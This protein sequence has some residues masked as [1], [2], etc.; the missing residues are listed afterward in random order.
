[1]RHVAMGLCSVLVL[2]SAGLADP[3]AVVGDQPRQTQQTQWWVRVDVKG[4]SV[5]IDPQNGLEG[6]GFEGA[7]RVLPTP[8]VAGVHS[9]DGSRVAFLGTPKGE[10]TIDL[11]VSDL[12]RSAGTAT[13]TNV[14]RITRG[15]EH[16][17]EPRWMHDNRTLLYVATS[18]GLQQVYRVDV[19]PWRRTQP[20]DEPRSER[21]SDGKTRSYHAR[22]SSDGK[23]AFL[24]MRGRD[25]KASLDDLVV[26]DGE[27]TKVVSSGEMILGLEFSPDGSKIAYSTAGKLRIHDL[28]TKQTHAW[29]FKD[30]SADH[31][32]T[33]HG[34]YDIAWRP[35]GKQIACTLSFL[36]GV[37]V[38]FP[39]PA[40]PGEP[41]PEPKWPV[42]WT[43]DK[44][45][46]FPA[47]AAE[48]PGEL[49]SGDKPT[50]IKGPDRQRYG[51]HGVGWTAHKEA[52]QGEA[53]NHD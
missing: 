30:L 2:A 47:G 21:V 18:R 9:P 3:P 53:W 45:F 1:M 41:A 42:F 37:S 31:M 52:E 24:V 44:V 27:A 48:Q 20:E 6:K 22:A 7:W 49:R 25:G 11:F 23:I 32:L 14:R 16:V 34:A 43:D 39:E 5:V 17:A 12:D 26:I 19:G 4:S 36:G 51:V 35:D 50:W 33:S 28:V 10:A 46:L 38:G 29:H 8:E 40:K 15:I 13:K